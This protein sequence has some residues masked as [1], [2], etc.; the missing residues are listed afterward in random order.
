MGHS[1]ESLSK[2]L[3]NYLV[4]GAQAIEIVMQQAESAF[5]L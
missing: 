3:L 4:A 5:L 2:S 1:F